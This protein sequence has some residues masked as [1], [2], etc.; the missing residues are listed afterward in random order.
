MNKPGI[1]IIGAGNVGTQLAKAFHKAAYPIVQIC[2]RHPKR[3]EALAGLVKASSVI[4]VADL[5]PDADIFILCIPD[6]SIRDLIPIWPIHNKLLCHTS[7]STEMD[8]LK[9][10]S[11]HYGV[12]YPLQTFSSK[13]NVN[14]S[15]VPIC[16][17]ANSQRNGEIL[18]KI[19]KS[20]S[21]DVRYINTPARLSIHIA[22]V[23]AGNFPN[24][25]YVLAEEILQKNGYSFEILHPLIQETSSK[26]VKISPF[27]A[28]TGPARRND[29]DIIRK[30][31]ELLRSNPQ[32]REIYN[33]ITQNIIKHF[34]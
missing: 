22:A 13:K 14:F 1:S 15:K 20:L 33:L 34:E 7:G 9:D 23:I 12:F 24:F 2:S 16:I 3:A 21:G 29:T 19:G 25:M 11:E 5:S 6:Q 10:L 27:K 17:E 31:L 30:H 28:Q 18:Y 26:A 32:T 8:V 4:S